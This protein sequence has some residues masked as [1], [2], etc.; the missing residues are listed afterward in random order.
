[1]HHKTCIQIGLIGYPKPIVLTIY[2]KKRFINKY[3]SYK[4]FLSVLNLSTQSEYFWTHFQ[5][6]TWLLFLIGVSDLAASLKLLL[7][8]KYRYKPYPITA[9]CVCVLVL[10][11]AIKG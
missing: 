9:G 6:D 4:T 7:E 3:P 8:L 5:I 2:L 11:M 1:M 10:Y